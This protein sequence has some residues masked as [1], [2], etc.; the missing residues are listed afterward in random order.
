HRADI[1]SLGCT[2]Y[3]L[4]TGKPPFEGETSMEKVFAHR[5]QPIPQL[6]TASRFLQPVLS[7]MMAKRP[8]DR[9]GSMTDVIAVLENAGRPPR[10]RRLLPIVLLGG[11]AVAAAAAALIV[12]LTL[13][14]DAKHSTAP[15]PAVAGPAAPVPV[16]VAPAVP[17][18][19]TTEKAVGAE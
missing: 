9:Y 2:L 5:E 4:L 7:K 1:Y 19:A 16:V 8:E 14:G 11:G 15:A 13:G 17:V 18:Q 3:F 10:R 12:A 6:P